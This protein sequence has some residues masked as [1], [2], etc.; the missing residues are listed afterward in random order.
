VRNEANSF[1]IKDLCKC[2]CH[3]QS[4]EITFSTTC[5]CTIYQIQAEP[6]K[7]ANCG[8]REPNTIKTSHTRARISTSIGICLHMDL[9]LRAVTR[10]RTRRRRWCIASQCT[11]RDVTTS[12][13]CPFP[14]PRPPMPSNAA[15]LGGEEVWRGGTGCQQ[16]EGAVEVRRKVVKVTVALTARARNNIGVLPYVYACVGRVY[17]CVGCVC[18][19]VWV[20]GGGRECARVFTHAR[21]HMYSSVWSARGERTE[22]LFLVPH[23]AAFLTKVCRLDA[24]VVRVS[25]WRTLTVVR[26]RCSDGRRHTVWWSLQIFLAILRRSFRLSLTILATPP[27]RHSTLL[28]HVMYFSVTMLLFQLK[29]SPSQNE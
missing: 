3:R 15:S 2:I 6:S 16:R 9:D 18:M 22:D 24:R 14:Y 23:A 29:M 27:G 1:W 13:T 11:P 19:C 10:A 21:A 25:Q 17:A 26:H 28:R 20:E 8:R 12:G 7:I 4:L 5:I